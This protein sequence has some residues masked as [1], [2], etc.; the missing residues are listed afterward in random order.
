MENSEPGL[1]MTNIRKNKEE[2][3]IDKYIQVE[4]KRR[5]TNKE[6]KKKEE[7]QV[8]RQLLKQNATHIIQ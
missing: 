5:K 8:R 2:K 1:C 4:G 6:G 7:K 3:K